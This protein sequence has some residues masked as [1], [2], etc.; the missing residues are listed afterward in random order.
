LHYDY[1][2]GVCLCKEEHKLFHKTYG[3]KNNTPEQYYEFKELR[4]KELSL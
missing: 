2:L 3:V 4:L 1:G